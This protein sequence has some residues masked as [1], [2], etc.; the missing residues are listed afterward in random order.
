MYTMLAY[1]KPSVPEYF[2]WVI[3]PFMFLTAEHLSTP[4]WCF[5]VP[6]FSSHPPSRNP[7][8]A[9][10][11]GRAS[12]RHKKRRNGFNSL[13]TPFKMNTVLHCFHKLN[14]FKLFFFFAS[15][16]KNRK[17]CIDYSFCCAG[18]PSSPWRGSSLHSKRGILLE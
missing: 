16:T 9:H 4:F 15:C 1:M 6:V 17:T 13:I 10:Q 8:Y 7:L 3:F 2:H 14:V 11:T 18:I 5:A 12:T